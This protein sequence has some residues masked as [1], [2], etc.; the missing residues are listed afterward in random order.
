L[1]AWDRRLER[2]F[3]GHRVDALDPVFV[4]LSWVGSSGGIWIAL[5]LA[6]AY[7]RNRPWLVAWTVV[8]VAV[9]DLG[10]WG[11]KEAID[12]P[13]PR[14]DHLVHLPETGSFPSGHAATSF[15]CAVLLS[16]VAPRLA[17][18]LF[19]LA[20]AIAF[21]RVYVGVHFPLDVLG[22]A[23][24]GVLVATALPLLATGLRRSLPARR[25][26]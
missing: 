20:A 5:A 13:R 8:F 22:G 11:L 2:W 24:L 3:I 19:L 16:R 10:A 1:T 4:A 26:G 17:P 7:F 21:S 9:A 14:V 12:R 18:V 23:A 15:A 25:R 6:I